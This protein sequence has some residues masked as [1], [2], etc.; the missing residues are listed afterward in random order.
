MDRDRTMLLVLALAASLLAAF[1]PAAAAVTLQPAAPMGPG[2]GAVAGIDDAGR[3][4]VAWRRPKRG[5]SMPDIVWSTLDTRGRWSPAT[6]L[7]DTY[8]TG[9]YTGATWTADQVAVAVAPNGLTLIAWNTP[10]DAVEAAIR[11]AGARAFGTPVVLRPQSESGR[12]APFGLTAA[13]GSDGTGV[14]AWSRFTDGGAAI[15]AATLQGGRF[16]AAAEVQ[17][18]G[19]LVSSNPAVVADGAGDVLALFTVEGAGGSEDVVLARRSGAGA[20]STT[21]IGTAAR[22]EGLADEVSL[23][24]GRTGALAAAWRSAPGIAAAL[25]RGST[26]IA[27]GAS[28]LLTTAADAEQPVAHVD[29]AGRAIVTWRTGTFPNMPPQA[30]EAGIDQPFGPAFALPHDGASMATGSAFANGTLLATTRTGTGQLQQR[31]AAQPS[32][33][34]AWTAASTFAT[35]TGE[36][37]VAPTLS[38]GGAATITCSSIGTTSTLWARST[39]RDRAAPALGVWT[40][41]RLTATQ[42]GVELTLSCPVGERRCVGSAQLRAGRLATSQLLGATSF[43]MVGGTDRAAR[44]TLTRAGAA[45]R[46][47]RVVF[48]RYVVRDPAGNSTTIVRRHVIDYIRT[49]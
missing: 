5:F 49:I 26:G 2:L 14:V 43:N 7:P 9:S 27:P 36:F 41:P 17:P 48:A 44:L 35:V 37:E 1:V 28:T 10:Y 22:Q 12:G 45:L 6:I 47:G 32:V 15:D 30:A 19:S 16:A 8:G 29:A 25:G 11:P 23:A 34:S 3:T 31:T 40:G 13:I 33:A 21:K 42:R 38:E 39:I 46:T 20:W 4:T 18:A 24:V